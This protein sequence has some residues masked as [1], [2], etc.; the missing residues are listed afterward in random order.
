M[1][2][3]GEEPVFEVAIVV[4]KKREKECDENRACVEF[5]AQE[6]KKAGLIVERV[7]GIS[8]EFIKVGFLL[9]DVTV[10]FFF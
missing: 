10:L 4:P 3:R 7:C 9:I 5:F 6:L 8:D 2:G 1:N